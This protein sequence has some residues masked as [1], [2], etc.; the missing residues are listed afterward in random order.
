MVG[1]VLLVQGNNMELRMQIEASFIVFYMYLAY[2]R[3]LILLHLLEFIQ[4]LVISLDVFFSSQLLL[5]FAE[6]MTWSESWAWISGTVSVR[7][8]S[9]VKSICSPIMTFWRTFHALQFRVHFGDSRA[10]AFVD[11]VL[12]FLFY[13]IWNSWAVARGISLLALFDSLSKASS[14]C[15]WLSKSLSSF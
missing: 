9:M 3:I 5:Y 12:A 6:D 11:S 1:T 14:F 13:K 4:R 2:E 8:L 10:P 15:F 7:W